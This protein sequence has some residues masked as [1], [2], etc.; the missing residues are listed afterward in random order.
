MAFSGKK[1]W[2]IVRSVLLGVV[3]VA[4]LSYFHLW[5]V[6]YETLPRSP[7]KAIGRIYPDNFHGFVLY[8]TRQESLRLHALQYT[9]LT[10]GLV[11]VLA[12]ALYQAR[13]RSG[14]GG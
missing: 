11:V 2:I 4:A 6:Y 9:W 14:A 10:L 7:D 13:S 12:E 5:N 3:V 8:E 1:V